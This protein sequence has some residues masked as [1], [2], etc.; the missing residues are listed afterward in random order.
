MNALTCTDTTPMINNLY[1]GSMKYVFDSS[2]FLLTSK[3]YKK[4]IDSTKELDCC[5]TIQDIK[6]ENLSVIIE[7][8]QSITLLD[9]DIVSNTNTVEKEVY[10]YGRLIYELYKHKRKVKNDNGI[11]QFLNNF[12]LDSA[13]TTQSGPGLITVG[14]SYTAGVGVKNTERFGSILAKKL[15]LPETTLSKAG[16]SM[17]W[18]ADQL[19]RFDLKKD[20]V[21]VW[22]LTTSDRIEYFED[23]KYKSNTITNCLTI[24]KKHMPAV[25]QND[26]LI[27]LIQTF[28]TV[29]QV[30]NFCDRV[31]AKLFIVNLLNVSW[32]PPMLENQ[33]DIRWLD[34]T[35]DSTIRKDT[36]VPQHLDYGTD[37]I[38]PGPKQHKIY[39]EEIYNFILEN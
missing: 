29:M 17:Q 31:G 20:D 23:W 19:L 2:L 33:K 32:L 26:T 34:L 35:V 22:G 36:L 15:E 12:K 14:C 1:I 11:L 37:N 27:R 28:A 16:A 10:E 8:A 25:E 6:T 39:A 30:Q 13:D 38:H 18:V 24:S 3:N 4:A 21:V 7:S 9:I 5:T